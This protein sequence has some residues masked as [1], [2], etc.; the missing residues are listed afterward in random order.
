MGL[1]SILYGTTKEWNSQNNLIAE[2]GTIYIYSDYSTTIINNEEKVVPGI[3]IGDGKAYL[4][5]TPFITQT[6][7]DTLFSHIYD[8]DRHTNLVEKNFWN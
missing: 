8:L 2:E 6:L 3:K 7:Q 5:D 4:I 1:R